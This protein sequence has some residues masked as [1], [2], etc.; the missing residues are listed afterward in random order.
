MRAQRALTNL[1]KAVE[2][3]LRRMPVSET[4]PDIGRLRRAGAVE[5]LRARL[6]PATAAEAAKRER[7]REALIRTAEKAHARPGT[8]DPGPC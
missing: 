7:E 2:D 3:F 8:D 4:G 5:A 1:S 6:I